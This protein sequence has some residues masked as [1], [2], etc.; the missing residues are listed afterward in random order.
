MQQ[1]IKPWILN[2]RKPKFITLTLKHSDDPLSVQLDTIYAA[3]KRLRNRK[4]WKSHIKGGMWLFQLTKSETSGQWHPHIHIIATGRYL[5]QSD[6]SLEWFKVTGTSNI[7]DIRAVRD[8]K[9]AAEYVA[10]YA[11]APADLSKL[12]FDDAIECFD[13]LAG[14][15][16]C[17]TFGVGKEIQLCPKKCEDADEWEDVGSF[18]QVVNSRF[19]DD[20]SAAIYSA[21][22]LKQKCTIIIEPP[23]PPDYDNE[24]AKE[25]EPETYKQAVFDWGSF[26]PRKEK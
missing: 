17:G 1:T 4:L 22:A 26:L 21:W 11:T 3:F 8:A 18:W 13:A 19:V 9:K 15:R 2:H 24:K 6:L 25:F 10:R 14:R 16:M 7:V 20:T 12:A 5:P 23:P